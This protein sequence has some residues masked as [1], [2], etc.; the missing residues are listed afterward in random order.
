MLLK[1]KEGVVAMRTNI[2][3]HCAQSHNKALDVGECER[4]LMYV[5]LNLGFS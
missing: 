3:I 4:T 2:G 1:R 5:K